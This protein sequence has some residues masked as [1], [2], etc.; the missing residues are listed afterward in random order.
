MY[1]PEDNCPFYRVTNFSHYSRNNVPDYNQYWSLMA[2]VCETRYKSVN[3]ETVVEDV[4]QGLINA[5]LI[6]NRSC[7]E[8]VWHRS[9]PETYPVPT[10]ER[11]ETVGP[12]LEYL[13]S[14]GVY[15]RG[16]MGAWKYEVGNMD[17]SFMQGK[18]WADKIVLGENE[19]TL[20]HPEIVNAP[21]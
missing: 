9:F 3:R 13:E 19:V 15:S 6:R 14:R 1:F 12:I 20:Y 5:G 2:E 16:R 4:I 11:D 21:K 8:N 7:I 18:E 17:H 10:L